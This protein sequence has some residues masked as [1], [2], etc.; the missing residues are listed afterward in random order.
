[1]VKLV[2]DTLNRLYDA[3]PFEKMSKAAML[4]ELLPT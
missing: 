3:A 4:A 1:V 2:L